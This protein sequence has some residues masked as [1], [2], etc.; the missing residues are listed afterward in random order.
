MMEWDEEYEE[1]FEYTEEYD[2]YMEEDIEDDPEQKHIEGID[3]P[4]LQA[5][6]IEMA[7]KKS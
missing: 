4:E 3:D 5:K 1:E 7:E 2:E 6:K